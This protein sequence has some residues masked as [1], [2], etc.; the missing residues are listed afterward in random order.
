MATSQ[1]DSITDFL[2]T[3]EN[4]WTRLDSVVHSR[5][6]GEEV[7]VQVGK[8]EEGPG[9]KSRGNVQKVH[10]GSGRTPVEDGSDGKSREK[11]EYCWEDEDGFGVCWRG[12]LSFAPAGG[13]CPG[14]F[15]G[16]KIV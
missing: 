10:R 16:A 9:Y 13:G 11:E 6:H 7:S 1:Q 12:L 15:G 3:G 14:H 4:A 2:S 5:H 8:E